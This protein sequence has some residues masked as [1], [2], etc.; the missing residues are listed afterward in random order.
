[1][2]RLREIEREGF[3]VDV[4]AWMACCN[5][6]GPVEAGLWKATLRIKT[7]V[8]RGRERRPAMYER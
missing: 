8:V 1:M 7:G 5:A 4:R 6:A 2:E 3:D